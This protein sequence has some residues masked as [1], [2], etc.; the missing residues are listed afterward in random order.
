MLRASGPGP[1]GAVTERGPASSGKVE[2]LSDLPRAR[3]A[4]S[5]RELPEDAAAAVAS[6]RGQPTLGQLAARRLR[7][8]DDLLSNRIGNKN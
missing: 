7:P 4:S 6:G 3:E 2:A 8:L 5:G 1:P